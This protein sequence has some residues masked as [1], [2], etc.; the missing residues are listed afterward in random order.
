M[1][2]DFEDVWAEE[3]WEIGELEFLEQEEILRDLENE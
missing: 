2:E 3:Q 1:F